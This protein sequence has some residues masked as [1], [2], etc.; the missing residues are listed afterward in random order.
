M[1]PLVMD[2][3]D[4]QPVRR[5]HP[6]LW[7]GLPAASL[8]AC[9]LTP[10][11]GHARWRAVMTGELGVI[12]LG[13]VAFLLPAILLGVLVFL[14]R[15]ELPRGVGWLMALGAVGAVYF[16]GEETSWAQHYL[17]Y[18]TPPAMARIN[19]QG[20]F[21][22]HNIDGLNVLNNLPRQMMT[23]AALVGG[24]ILPLVLRRRLRGP[25]VRKSIW[26]WL[27]AP[28]ELVPLSLLAVLSTVPEK[29]LRAHAPTVRKGDYLWM[30]CV[31]YAGEFKEYCFALVILLYFLS[32]HLRLRARP[33]SRPGRTGP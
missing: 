11:L 27:V 13:T 28:V 25:G 19:T 17:H 1:G 4:N 7:L 21:N 15:R 16:V 8:A 26:Y 22:F 14:R 6:L 31:K 2:K 32:I 12:E 10:L 18:Q 24:A 30:A 29:L 23:A 9:W 33:S 3:V 5:L 20:E